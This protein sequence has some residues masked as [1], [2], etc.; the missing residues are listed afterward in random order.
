MKLFNMILGLSISVIAL[1]LI[2]I[3]FVGSLIWY[4]IK[5]VI[6]NTKQTDQEEDE[7]EYSCCGDE[8]KGIYQDIRRCPTCKENI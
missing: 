1:P 4:M 8:V 5:E 3:V 7:I 2:F 6:K